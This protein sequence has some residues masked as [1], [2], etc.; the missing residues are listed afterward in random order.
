MRGHWQS[1]DVC[2]GE[3]RSVDVLRGVKRSDIDERSAF[4][5]AVSFFFFISNTPYAE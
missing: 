2:V 3:V 5:G 4:T 1:E